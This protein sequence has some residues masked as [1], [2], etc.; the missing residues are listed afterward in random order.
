MTKRAVI[1]ASVA[2]KWVLPENGSEAAAALRT[3]MLH[4]PHLLLVECGNALW[5]RVRR[6][7]LSAAEAKACFDLLSDAPVALAPDA[8]LMPA[9][10]TLA[11]ELDQTVYDCLY[12]ALAVKRDAS[13]VTADRRLC[14]AAKRHSD[15]KDRVLLLGP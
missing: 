8:E 13:L 12:L 7:V 3:T 2:L 10:L 11:L 1:D 9:A 6:N 4:A 15:L 14:A 5:V